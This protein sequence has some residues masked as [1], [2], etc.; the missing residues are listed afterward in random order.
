MLLAATAGF[1]LILPAVA[2][3]N[4]L[5][6][7]WLMQTGLDRP[8]ELAAPL[9]ARMVA[10]IL[11]LTGI[12]TAASGPRIAVTDGTGHVS[13]LWIAWN[14]VGWQSLIL[15][16]ISL[17][18]G[19]QGR[20]SWEVRIQVILAG[21]LGTILVNLLRISAVGVLVVEVG[22]V[23]AQVFHDYGGTLLVMAWLFGFWALANGW[24]VRAGG[25]ER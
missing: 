13:Q 4:D 20:H 24:L 18:A 2:S 14:C 17:A 1:L 23:P 5:L 9:E 16:G 22:R 10:A 25:G 11:S 7:A 15:L 6:T 3:F 8:V 21:L 12:Q 19:L